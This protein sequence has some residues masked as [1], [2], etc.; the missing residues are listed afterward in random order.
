M[1]EALPPFDTFR[2]L[3]LSPVVL[4]MA[5]LAQRHEGVRGIAAREPVAGLAAAPCAT[6][7]PP[8]RKHLCDVVPQLY[9]RLEGFCKPV[10]S[11]M[12]Y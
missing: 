4:L 1:P 10:T 7:F 6:L 8:L 5:V 3:H 2:E 12:G 9:L 11:V